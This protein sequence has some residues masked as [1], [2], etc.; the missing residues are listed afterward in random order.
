MFDDHKIRLRNLVAAINSVELN[1]L[2]DEMEEAEKKMVRSALQSSDYERIAWVPVD[3]QLPGARD[4][5]V[6]QPPSYPIRSLDTGEYF[7]TAAAINSTHG[8]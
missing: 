1:N 4:C 5:R 7:K 6:Q 8:G 2:L 3:E